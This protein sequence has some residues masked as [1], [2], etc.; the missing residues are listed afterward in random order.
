M[1]LANPIPLFGDCLKWINSIWYFLGEPLRFREM[2]SALGCPGVALHKP[3][4]RDWLKLFDLAEPPRDRQKPS[5]PNTRRTWR[6][7]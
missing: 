1:A 6:V 2:H 5:A 4:E 3:H 7:S